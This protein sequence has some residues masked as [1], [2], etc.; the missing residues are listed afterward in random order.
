MSIVKASDSVK[1][2]F[3]FSVDKFPLA[4]PD[5]MTTPWYGLFRSDNGCVV[6]NG[7]VTDRYVPHSSDDV[8]ALTEAVDSIFDG[9]VE[10]HCHFRNGHYVNIAPSRNYRKSIFNQRDNVFPRIM[11]RAG[12]DG[13]A[14]NATVGYY[15]DLCSNLAMLSS[16]DSCHVSI[17]HTQSLRSKMDELV[18]T[19][20]ELKEGWKSLGDVI[21]EMNSRNVRMADFLDAIYGQ[22]DT[23]SKRAVTVHRNRT[24]AIFRRLQKERYHAGRPAMP[25]NFEVSAWEA[26]NAIQGFAQHDSTRR[27]GT[28][29]FDRILLAANDPAVQKAER[30]ALAA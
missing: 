4:G 6:G 1:A 9:D 27:S 19:F 12:Y 11:I 7:S 10:A 14:F 3:D 26:Y 24:E 5:G 13:R 30:L 21:T 18:E 28:T 15:R 8:M 20:A 16:V 17:R 29:Q 22:P 25:N 23:D 2:A